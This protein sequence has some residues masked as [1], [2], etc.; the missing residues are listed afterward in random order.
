MMTYGGMLLLFI[1]RRSGGGKEG[2]ERHELMSSLIV[3]L[4]AWNGPPS[5]RGMHD[6]FSLRR[7]LDGACLTATTI[8]IEKRQWPSSPVQQ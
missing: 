4:Q 3:C 1:L 2:G 6:S 5:A 7:L 8:I